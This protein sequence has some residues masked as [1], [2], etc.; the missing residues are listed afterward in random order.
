MHGFT[1]YRKRVKDV[2][3]RYRRGLVPSDKGH[4]S[5]VFGCRGS[6]PD[7]LPSGF[8]LARSRAFPESSPRPHPSRTTACQDTRRGT[9]L[10]ITQTHLARRLP[11]DEDERWMAMHWDGDERSRARRTTVVSPG[12]VNLGVDDERIAT[13]RDAETVRPEPIRHDTHGRNRKLRERCTHA[14]TRPASMAVRLLAVGI[15]Q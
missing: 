1:P 2:R 10:S 3:D 11:S 12:R 8:N 6:A 13:L 4:A 7:R 14:P 5:L 15:Q 9:R